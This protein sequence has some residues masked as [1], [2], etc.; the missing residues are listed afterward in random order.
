MTVEE[1]LAID[2]RSEENKEKLQ[3]A[4]QK[5]KPFAQYAEEGKKVPLEKIEK[6][7][8][9]MCRKYYLVTQYMMFARIKDNVSWY[10]LS[11]KKDDTGEWLGT[12]YGAT[13][14][15]TFAKVAILLY[16][17]VRKGEVKERDGDA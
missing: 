3:K 17:A 10:N 15:E 13:L 9:K 6:L 5:I 4:L 7:I 14:Y 11:C 8:D 12:V 2:C 1:I 16:S